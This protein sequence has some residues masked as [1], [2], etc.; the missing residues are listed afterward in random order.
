MLLT[1]ACLTAGG[2]G[3]LV[4]R[5]ETTLNADGSVD[6]AIFQPQRETPA[7][8]L[9]AE[10]WQQVTYSPER[11]PEK[12]EKPISELPTTAPDKDLPYV[13][14]W[15]HFKSAADL[16]DHFLKKA[17]EGLS[18]GKLVR[19]VVV[20]DYTLATEYHWRET[21]SDTVTLPAMH[22]AV[23]DLSDLMI[24]L[25]RHTLDEGLGKEYDA[26]SLIKWCRKEGKS[27]VK[28]AAD[29]LFE[30][31]IRKGLKN[32]EQVDVTLARVGSRH[33]LQLVDD[34]GAPL[35]RDEM[36]AALREFFQ[37]LIREN[38]KRKDGQPVPEEVL[39]S[40]LDLLKPAA[41]K[42]EDGPP[43]RENR[44]E[45]ACK[46]VIE[47]KYDGA[48]A[49]QKRVGALGMRIAGLYQSE[50]FGPPR[51]F[52]YTLKVPGR[53]VETNG[54]IL[55]ENEVEWSFDSTEA[56]PFG[57]TMECRSLV[58]S[59]DAQR[60]LL[61]SEPLQK[62]E[63]LVSFGRILSKDN[64]L[65]DVL[66]ACVAADSL[67]PFYDHHKMLQSDEGSEPYRN[68]RRLFHLLKLPGG[69]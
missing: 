57:Y 13:A 8:V 64:D 47:R 53:I 11:E 25:L 45:I 35:S 61:N 54:S 55:S 48:E 24:D 44:F 27:W 37:N 23:A 3:K 42:Q 5:A 56:F 65:T 17:V 50:I 15:G 18:D 30:L 38:V 7:E 9:Q 58:P 43:A 12:W 31:G 59:P 33:G 21:L 68:A 60:K 46:K 20:V 62:W 69:L 40:L 66:K 22:K 14:A 16:P 19:D 34:E 41:P 32:R 10:R 63:D 49:F 28:D 29:A 6:R 36:Q 51:L 4:Y 67:K 2:C 39:H 26:T 52:H 1:L